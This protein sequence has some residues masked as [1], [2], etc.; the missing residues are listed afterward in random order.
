MFQL[1]KEECLTSQIVIL[2]MEQGKHLKYMPYVFTEMGVA[3]LSSLL[4][5][6]TALQVNIHI[7]RA[8]NVVRR[9]L[10]DS[11]ID[12]VS[13]LR[14]EVKELQK[15]IEEVFTDQNDINEDTRMQLELINQTLAQLQMRSKKQ[16][17]IKR[18]RIGFIRPEEE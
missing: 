13:E 6:N 10:A 11:P 17:K 1:N 2:D 18:P 3:K 5:S 4:R 15:Y 9:I 14:Q 12:K 7:M 8:F 16:E